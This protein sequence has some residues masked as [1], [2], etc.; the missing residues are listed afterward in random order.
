MA[1]ILVQTDDRLTVL[2]E[3]GVNPADIGSE[4]A[5]RL[6]GRIERAVE[7]ADRRRQ[8]PRFKRL[9]VI[10]PASDYREIVRG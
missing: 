9:G 4:A 1:R 3:G 8:R 10:A 7:D 2:D 6:L 5:Q